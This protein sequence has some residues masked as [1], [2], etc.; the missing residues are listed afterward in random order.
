MADK[1]TVYKLPVVMETVFGVPLRTVH[2]VIREFQR[3]TGEDL[4]RLTPGEAAVA[5]RVAI[6]SRR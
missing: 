4:S 6:R 3:I 2:A 5:L 1:D